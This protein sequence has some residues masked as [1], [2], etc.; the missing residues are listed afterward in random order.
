MKLG[1]ITFKSLCAHSVY[2]RWGG[3]GQEIRKRTIKRRNRSSGRVSERKKK[4]KMKL[5]YLKAEMG[6]TEGRRGPAGVGGS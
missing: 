4:E 2:Y 3:A 1:K 6:L 5:H